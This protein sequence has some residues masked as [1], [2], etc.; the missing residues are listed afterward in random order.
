[1]ELEELD[2]GEFNL[3]VSLWPILF[4][5]VTLIIVL[6]KMHYAIQVLEEKVKTIFQLINKINDK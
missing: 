4:G 3:M 2:M 1:L 5:I 6:A